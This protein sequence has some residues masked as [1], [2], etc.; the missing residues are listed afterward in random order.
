MVF[1]GERTWNKRCEKAR[2]LLKQDFGINTSGFQCKGYDIR[3]G[4]GNNNRIPIILILYKYESEKI[5]CREFYEFYDTKWEYVGYMDVK[6]CLDFYWKVKG[7]DVKKW[8]ADDPRGIRND[9]DRNQIERIME[10]E[11][12]EYFIYYKKFI[13][14]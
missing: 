1:F 3:W 13:K 5:V 4:T 2:E 10:L 12:D 14:R 9:K 8:Y 11:L 7:V 6:N